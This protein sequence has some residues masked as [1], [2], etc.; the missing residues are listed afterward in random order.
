M[1]DLTKNTRRD[2]WKTR[3]FA[4]SID[5]A[6]DLRSFTADEYDDNKPERPA[7]GIGCTGGDNLT[8][9][10]GSLCQFSC[11]YGFCPESICECLD[12]DQE[13]LQLPPEIQN[14][15]VKAYDY[16]NVELNRL[17]KFACRYGY[18]P[19]NICVKPLIELDTGIP[20][21]GEE[22]AYYNTT[23]A[24]LQN[25][26]KCVIFKDAAYA[27]TSVNMCKPVCKDKVD[28]AM[29]EGRTTNYG[30][31]DFWPGLKKI[32]WEQPMGSVAVAGGRYMCDN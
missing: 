28:E 29:A 11:M 21:P 16:N 3:N 4:G 6:V 7:S 22:A 13:L 2:E 12:E 17:C 10:S 27:D 14:L 19:D 32:P 9:D 5:W 31:V 15:N 20:E 24:E 1:S 18:C 26:Q 25:Q 30:C 8:L 23:E